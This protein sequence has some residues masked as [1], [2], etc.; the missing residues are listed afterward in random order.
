MTLQMT[1]FQPHGKNLIAGD[2]VFWQ[3][4][5]LD[6]LMVMMAIR[7]AIQMILLGYG[8]ILIAALGIVWTTRRKR[9]VR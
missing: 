9:T 8:V 7:P 6:I 3:S 5:N 1:G 2:W 4:G